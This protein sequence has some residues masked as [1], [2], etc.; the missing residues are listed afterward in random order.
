MAV[1]HYISADSHV[2]EPAELWVERMDQAF[3]GQAPRVVHSPADFE[4]DT[5]SL[6]TAS[7]SRLYKASSPVPAVKATTNF[8]STCA[9]HGMR[10]GFRVPTIPPRDYT[11][12]PPTAR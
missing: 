5:G 3:R 9:R 8:P 12:W 2:L 4:G 7:R 6:A 1:D 10:H 11:I